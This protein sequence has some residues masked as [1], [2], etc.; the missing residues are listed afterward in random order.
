MSSLIK[1]V[2]ISKSF[3]GVTYLDNISFSI[4]RGDFLLIAGC[5]GSGK[6]LLMKHLNGLFPIKKGTLFYMGEDCFKKEREMKS[7]VGIVFQNPDTQIIGLT[8]EDDI[9]FGPS[10]LG[11]KRSEIEQRVNSVFRR[12]SIE[13]LRGRNPHT[14]SGG[15]KKRVTIAGVLA[16]NPTIIIFDEPFIGLDYPGV[17][18]VTRSLLRLKE[19]GETVIIITHDLE[20]IAAYCN[21]AIILSEGKIVMQGSISNIIDSVEKWGIRR[22]IQNSISEM[23]WLK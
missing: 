8:V 17:I 9:A 1:T 6:T 11:L 14:L 12:M 13:H 20:K 23:T 5:N 2:G 4:N 15:E 19:E 16:M 18:D 10:N 3:D 22:P 7:R 21:G